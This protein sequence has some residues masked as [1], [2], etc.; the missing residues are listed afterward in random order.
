MSLQDDISAAIERA[1]GSV[2]RARV[3][4]SIA[5]GS[6]NR[7]ASI[8]AGGARY[9]VKLNDA[10]ASLEMF[11]A[12]AA[13]LRLL[14]QPGVLRVPQPICCGTSGVTAY[15]VL[16]HIELGRGG[17]PG[18]ECLGAGLAGIHRMTRPRFGWDRDNTIGSTPQINRPTD[19]WVAFYRDHRLGFQ[20]EL[21]E[22][23]GYGGPLTKAGFRLLEKLPLVCAGH[24]PVASLLHGDL[25]GGNAAF[26]RNG[27]PVLY[28]PAVYFG[29]RETDLAMTELFGGFDASF[30]RAY[31]AAWPLTVGYELRRDLYQLYHV[32]NHLN[33]FGAGYADHARRL[34]DRLLAAVR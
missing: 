33:I 14:A 22:R 29:D 17:A 2:V 18:A 19:D 10:P 6:I 11:E 34:I 15:L 24:H 13:G 7:T 31:Q 26:D 28:D 1:T 9:F 5:S 8:G 27:V 32:L 16:E 12:E 3:P 4:W 20:L 25:W 30:Y 21:A 23:N